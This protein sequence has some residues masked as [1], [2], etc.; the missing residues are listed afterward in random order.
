MYLSNAVMGLMIIPIFLCLSF[1]GN[2]QVETTSGSTFPVSL[3]RFIRVAACILSK[4][5]KESKH[6]SF[7]V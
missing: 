6:L 4:G 3:T 5:V 2:G 7:P 1:L